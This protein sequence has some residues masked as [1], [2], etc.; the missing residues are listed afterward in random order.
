LPEKKFNG[1]PFKK[2]NQLTE[3][4]NKQKIKNYK[5]NKNGRLF[6]TLPKISQSKVLHWI[7]L[8]QLFQKSKLV[9]NSKMLL[10]CRRLPLN[11]SRCLS[12]PPPSCQNP[13]ASQR[14]VVRRPPSLYDLSANNAN[15]GKTD[16]FK[17]RL[18]LASKL[19]LQNPILGSVCILILIF[20]IDN[21]NLYNNL[22]KPLCTVCA[23]PYSSQTSGPRPPKFS[24]PDRVRV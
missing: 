6:R 3:N 22:A 14:D 4:V 13:A 17:R 21:D 8:L 18:E 16:F 11:F 10:K 15:L 24:Q 23:F 9:D 7:Q 19:A 1:F 2:S 5:K 12:T 20:Y